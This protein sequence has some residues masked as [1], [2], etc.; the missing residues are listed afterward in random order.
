LLL[1]ELEESGGIKEILDAMKMKQVT[2]ENYLTKK[3]CS[4][5]LHSN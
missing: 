5:R 2:V 4:S 1:Q 3:L